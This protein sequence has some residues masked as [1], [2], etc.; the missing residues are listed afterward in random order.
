MGTAPKLCLGRARERCPWKGKAPP[1]NPS[2]PF[3]P[4]RNILISSWEWLVGRLIPQRTE[5]L[6]GSEEVGPVE[7]GGSAGLR[8]Q[9]GGKGAGGEQQAAGPWAIKTPWFGEG[10]I[11]GL[12][13][14]LDIQQGHPL[15]LVATLPAMD[16]L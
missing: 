1:G 4:G 6:G 7:A 9:A 14:C 12:R 5:S 13:S 2:H 10:R 11:R 8:S 15:V 3:T 16:H